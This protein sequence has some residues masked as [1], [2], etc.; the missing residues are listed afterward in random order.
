MISS[1]TQIRKNHD[2]GVFGLGKEHDLPPLGM[3]LESVPFAPAAN[4]VFSP[5]ELEARIAY[6]AAKHADAPPDGCQCWC[7]GKTTSRTSGFH[8]MGWV[9]RT[10]GVGISHKEIYCGEC[11]AEWGW[12]T[13]ETK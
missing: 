7:C 2:G 4:V 8:L 1:P 9:S 5:E 12:P 3:I 11:F 6:Y 13:E 10:Y